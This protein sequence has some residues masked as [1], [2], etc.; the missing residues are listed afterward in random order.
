MS[1]TDMLKMSVIERKHNRLV[2]L[3]GKL[4]APWTDELNSLCRT[5]ASHPDQLKLVIDL[6]G[7]TIV[8][9]EG[10]DVL[11][12]L[13]D[14]GAKF[15]GSDLFTKQILKQLAQRARKHKQESRNLHS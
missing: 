9:A 6:R 2:V 10:E 15:R 1:L 3:E 13:M 12:A 4:I 5:T 8:S 11:R 14:R 7:I